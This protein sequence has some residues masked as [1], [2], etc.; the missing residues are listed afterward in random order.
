MRRE[1]S[2]KPGRAAEARR[3]WFRGTIVPR[4]K[5]L[6]GSPGR[7]CVTKHAQRRM[8]PINIQS[9]PDPVCLLNSSLLS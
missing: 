8:H 1:G 5:P 3:R 2:K 4:C 6:G 9:G 7:N